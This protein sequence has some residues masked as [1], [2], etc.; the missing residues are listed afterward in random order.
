MLDFLEKSS[1]IV[2]GKRAAYVGM[3]C[4]TRPKI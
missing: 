2:H 1:K 3:E 4:T